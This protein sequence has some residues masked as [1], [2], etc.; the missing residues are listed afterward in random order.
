MKR[1]RLTRRL[2]YEQAFVQEQRGRQ[3]LQE[4]AKLEGFILQ[5]VVGEPSHSESAVDAAIRLLRGAASTTGQSEMR[6]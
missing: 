1:K 6:E 4:I 3:A 5:E 2:L